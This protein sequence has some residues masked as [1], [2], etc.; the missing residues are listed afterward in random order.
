MTSM[1]VTRGPL[2]AHTGTYQD[3]RLLRM[4]PTG[5]P[6]PVS[7]PLQT[8]GRR[9]LQW[10]EVRTPWNLRHGGT[11]W[12]HG[13]YIGPAAGT[14]DSLPDTGRAVLATGLAVDGV[15]K[16]ADA[17]EGTRIDAD[18]RYGAQCV[19]LVKAWAA[20]HGI[21]PAE[22]FGNGKDVAANLGRRPGWAFKSATATP[23]PGWVP[24]WGHPFGVAPD[25]TLYGHTAVVL[26]VD[27]DRLLV[28]QQD[29]FDEAPRAYRARMPREGVLGYA[30]PPTGEDSP[31][32]VVAAG[33]TL[34]RIADRVGTD[35]AT[36]ARVNGLEDPDTIL[37][38]QV[39][40]VAA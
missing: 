8:T 39:L 25:G 10:V 37:V 3:G 12:V 22:A 1:K 31:S 29:G 5:T 2:T 35:V 9:R 4:R 33:D 30:V 11:V 28:L 15:T 14:R 16:W 7:T 19:D 13:D 40:K 34:S 26:G 18:S 27:G 20:E 32:V 17:V 6:L 24:S 23:A 38:G 21:D 36:L